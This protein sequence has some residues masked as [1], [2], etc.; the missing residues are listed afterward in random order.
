MV[1][2]DGV[3]FWVLLHIFNLYVKCVVYA[4]PGGVLRVWIVIKVVH[5]YYKAYEMIFF[6]YY[7]CYF[8]AQYVYK[9]VFIIIMSIS[10]SKGDLIKP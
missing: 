8:Y 6:L 1:Y 7:R 9:Y 3:S 5:T 2:G 10:I 4:N